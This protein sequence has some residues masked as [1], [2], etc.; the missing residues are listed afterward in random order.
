MI[1]FYSEKMNEFSLNMNH[2]YRE[3]LKVVVIKKNHELNFTKLVPWTGKLRT[4]VFGE[5]IWNVYN[6]LEK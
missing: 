4:W 3:G 5:F 2:F 1:I 6:Q